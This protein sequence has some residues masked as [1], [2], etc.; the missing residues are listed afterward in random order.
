MRC[1]HLNTSC[2][3]LT[4]GGIDPRYLSWEDVKGRRS[5]VPRVGNAGV[6]AKRHCSGSTIAKFI[7]A[8]IPCSSY[9][10]HFTQYIQRPPIDVLNRSVKWNNVLKDCTSF[11]GQPASCDK[12][13]DT[14]RR[15]CGTIRSVYAEL[16]VPARSVTEG[17]GQSALETDQ[18]WQLNVW[19]LSCAKYS[20]KAV[21]DWLKSE[22]SNISRQ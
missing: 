16:F 17:V 10:T 18:G 20:G 1:A 19:A 3:R 22:T 7:H 12:K 5:I 11:K 9:T 15:T 2:D 14:W 21:K 8:C 6:L 4:P 13:F